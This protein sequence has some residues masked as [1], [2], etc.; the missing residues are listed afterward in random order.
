MQL[1]RNHRRLRAVGDVELG[2]DTGHVV[3]HG[4][5]ADEPC[6]ADLRVGLALHKQ[7]QHVKFVRG[8]VAARGRGRLRLQQFRRRSWGSDRRPRCTLRMASKR[9]SGEE[10]L[11]R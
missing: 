10:S 2:E 6:L 4:G 1:L 7:V 5:R 8:E 9:S 11:S 3:A